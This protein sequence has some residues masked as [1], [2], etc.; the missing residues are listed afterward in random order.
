M[1]SSGVFPCRFVR[2]EFRKHNIDIRLMNEVFPPW[3]LPNWNALPENCRNWPAMLTVPCRNDPRPSPHGIHI[4]RME[5]YLFYHLVMRSTV[6]RHG[7]GL[8]TSVFME[9]ISAEHR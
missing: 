1:G 7:Q 9:M 8:M 5:T 3:L 6:N 2:K 4:K